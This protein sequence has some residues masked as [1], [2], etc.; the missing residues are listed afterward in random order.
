MVGSPFDTRNQPFPIGG[1]T[2]GYNDPLSQ[3]YGPGGMRAPGPGQF[4]RGDPVPGMA[5]PGMQPPSIIQKAIM[6]SFN[7]L[8]PDEDEPRR[9][10]DDWLRG[11]AD[12]LGGAVQ[13]AGRW[14][15]NPDNL[16]AATNVLGTGAMIYGA[17]KDRKA[18]EEEAARQREIEE[19]ERAAYHSWDPERRR[20]LEEMMRRRNQGG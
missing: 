10:V 2:P 16:S 18:Y 3:P 1:Y 19:Q 11:G 12:W 4:L 9:G 15:R 20:I 6:P 8:R 14:L 13:G 17:H 5:G 7:M